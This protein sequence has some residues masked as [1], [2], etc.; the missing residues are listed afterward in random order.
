MGYYL[1]TFASWL[2]AD[3]SLSSDIEILS[4]RAAIPKD[5]KR[6][7]TTRWDHLAKQQSFSMPKVPSRRR[8]GDTIEEETAA[9]SCPIPTRM[10]KQASLSYPPRGGTGGTERRL[11]GDGREGGAR[12]SMVKQTSLRN[13][14]RHPRSLNSRTEVENMKMPRL[15]KQKSSSSLRRGLCNDDQSTGDRRCMHN[16]SNLPNL[17][18]R[19]AEPKLPVRTHDSD[20]DESS[21]NLSSMPRLVKQTSFTV[22]RL[23]SQAPLIGNDE[24]GA[25]GTDRQ[26]QTAKP[27]SFT[28]PRRPTRTFD[29]DDEL[30]ERTDTLSS[31]PRL[32]KQTSFTVARL[33]SRA[34]LIGGD[35]KGANGTY[36]LQQQTAKPDSFAMP[37]RPT[38]TSD[39]EDDLDERTDTLS[40]MPR[41]VKQTSFTVARHSSRAPLVGDDENGGNVIMPNSFSSPRR[42]TRTFDS[43]DK[44][45][46]FTIPMLSSGI[47]QS[48]DDESDDGSNAQP[49]SDA[50]PESS[51][52]NSDQIHESKST[53]DLQPNSNATPKS[54]SHNSGTKA[55]NQSQPLTYRSK[56]SRLVTLTLLSERSYAM[57]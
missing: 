14:P 40:S 3:M 39:S 51:P 8:L 10:M 42:P 22:A 9:E 57:P 48:E 41:L 44:P 12:P 18:S 20:R 34:P 11:S 30:D 46:S 24:K 29:S 5:R 43:E 32:V 15:V 45:T 2:R 27:D 35:E 53:S 16:A 38:R 28:M 54:S 50:T 31:M 56:S 55:T 33:S 13:I 26:Q 36:K 25:N 21:D 17:P 4:D 49:N 7:P 23:S 19:G 1:G 47:P 52:H 37:V 6:R